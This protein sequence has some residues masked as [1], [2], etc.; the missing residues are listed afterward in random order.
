MPI[1]QQRPQQIKK[2]PIVTLLNKQTG[3]VRGELHK[4]I[5]RQRIKRRE[6]VGRSDARKEVGKGR[7]MWVKV[8][9]N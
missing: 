3:D 7:G 8:G 2:N 1:Y 4:R 9:R 6:K 5:W